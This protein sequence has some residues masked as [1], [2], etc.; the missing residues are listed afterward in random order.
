MYAKGVVLI[1]I[2]LMMLMTV[3]W[4]CTTGRRA[5]VPSEIEQY[6]GEWMNMDFDERIIY[7]NDGT[8]ENYFGK[9][10]IPRWYG[11]LVITEQWK[12][13]EGAV[14]YKTVVENQVGMTRYVLSRIS[15]SG[16][17]LEQVFFSNDYP[18]ELDPKLVS[19]RVYKR[20]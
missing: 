19:Y 10:T 5:Y 9:A 12:D 11:T 8:F 16:T 6:Y 15:E 17:V 14:W 2:L 18:S 13:R 1:F 20:Q 7:K 4:G 3:V